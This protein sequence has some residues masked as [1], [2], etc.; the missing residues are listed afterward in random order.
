MHIDV[1]L[2]SELYAENKENFLFHIIF[3][4]SSPIRRLELS[5]RNNICLIQNALCSCTHKIRVY[6]YV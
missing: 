4:I 1:S 5:S 3:I 6:R 2:Q